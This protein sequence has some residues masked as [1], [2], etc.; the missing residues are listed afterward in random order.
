[1]TKTY[2]TIWQAP[3][4]LPYKTGR[5]S[6][7][8]LFSKGTRMESTNRSLRYSISST[9]ILTA[10]NARSTVFWGIPHALV[11]IRRL[12]TPSPQM[13]VDTAL[14]SSA[15]EC[16]AQKRL[17][18]WLVALVGSEPARSGRHFIVKNGITWE[19]EK[20]RRAVSLSHDPTPGKRCLTNAQPCGI[21]APQPH[22]P[23]KSNDGDKYA[24]R[25]CQRRRAVHRDRCKPGPAEARRNSLPS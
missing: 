10:S 14:G 19:S 2:A 21:I 1:M 13:R 8:G 9:G 15:R 16:D 24:E 6:R 17:L 5:Y 23:A 12:G 20:E 3:V 7:Y 22:I 4:S 18:L 25:P 11:R